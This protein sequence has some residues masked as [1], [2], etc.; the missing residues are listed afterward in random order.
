M[1]KGYTTDIKSEKSARAR[2]YEFDMS[3][4]KAYEVC[5]ALRGMNVEKAEKYLKDVIELKKAVPIKRYSQETAHKKGGVGPGRYPVKVAGYIL[6][7]IKDAK[8]NAEFKGLD[9]DNMKLVH[10]AASRGR[11]IQGRMPRAHGRSTEWNEQT[12]SIEIVL[13]E[14]EK[15]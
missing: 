10:I 7:L 15:E 14:R 2:G 3:P 8:A 4:K 13:E 9:P 6:K 11:I 5:N 1:A 12:T